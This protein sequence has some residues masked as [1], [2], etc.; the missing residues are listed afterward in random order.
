M[1]KFSCGGL[2]DAA[3]R[4]AKIRP[5]S[6]ATAGSARPPRHAGAERRARTPSW[7]IGINATPRACSK[8][9][10]H[11]E[12][13]PVP[14]AVVVADVEFFLVVVPANDC[15]VLI[16][17]RAI[18]ATAHVQREQPPVEP[19]GDGFAFSCRLLVLRARYG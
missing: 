3:P 1:T 18:N 2:R 10:E 7:R 17:P 16:A 12:G 9:L 13:C 19:R 11:A 4:K 8:P 15:S 6:T 14:V 5:P